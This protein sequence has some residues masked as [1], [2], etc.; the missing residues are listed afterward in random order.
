MDK[1][2]DLAGGTGGWR[3]RW[4]KKAA[5]EGFRRNKH[6]RSFL[7]SPPYGRKSAPSRDGVAGA[8]IAMRK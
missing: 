6:G 7:H 2:G 1:A 8:R 4:L 5:E 3:R